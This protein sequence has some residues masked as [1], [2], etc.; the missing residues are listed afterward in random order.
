VEQ[1]EF[2]RAVRQRNAFLKQGVDDEVTLSVWD[3]RMAM[4]GGRVM[5]RRARAVDAMLTHLAGAHRQVAESDVAV[6]LAYQSSWGG[7][8]DQSVSVSEL[9]DR[10]RAA[11]EERRRVDR[12]RRVTTVGP[13][14]DE[15]VLL[16]GGHDSRYHASQGEQRTM[17]LALRLAAHRAI[18]D[19]T[20]AA[21]VLLLDDVY[22]EL[23]PGRGAALTKALPVAQTIVTTAH[24][25]DV[26]LEGAVWSVGEGS[27]AAA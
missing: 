7:E 1:S 26:P 12:D 23:D 6:G 25:G 16:L 24:P 9:T 8:L 27:V 13:H 19:S 10:L 20:G 15:P 4:A 18:T 3:E 22:S 21:P 14:R 5:G 2:D 17:A 11:L